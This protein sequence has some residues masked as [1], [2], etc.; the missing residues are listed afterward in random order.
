MNDLEDRL[1]EAI[2][3]AV[4]GAEPRPGVLS[5]VRRRH[6]RWLIRVTGAGAAAAIVVAGV[7]VPLALLSPGSRVATATGDGA[8]GPVT[9]YV[10]GEKGTVT[11]I[12]TATNTPLKTIS[13]RGVDSLG[14]VLTPDGK[15]AYVLNDVLPAIVPSTVT[16]VR[17]ATNTALTPIK[18][19]AGARHFAMAPDGKTLY[20]ANVYSGTVTPIR[21]AT[22]I[23]LRPIKVGRHPEGIAVTPDSKTVYVAN[24]LAGTVTP[25]QAATGKALKPIKV[26]GYPWAIAI[27]PNGKTAY[28]ATAYGVVP[29]ATATNTALPLIRAGR[30]ALD[31]AITPN[32]STA[33]ALT[34]NGVTLIRTRHRHHP[35][36]GLGKA[37]PHRHRDHAGQRDRLR[38]RPSR[39]GDPHQHCD[40]QGTGP[41][42]GGEGCT[43]HRD[44]P[45]RQ[46]RL[47][48]ALSW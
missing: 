4:A 34:A 41:D 8:G 26:G 1:R 19:G 47:R 24:Y 22:N 38:H 17:T 44:H 21:T 14:I 7:V 9:A 10:V 39:R 29:I 40:R 13:D 15:T 48:H 31:V 27:T 37:G 30:G 11:P 16:P 25:I 23:T 2:N 42:R 45:G 36:A 35:A 12:R 33:Y 32:G 6:R 3:A 20:V 46:D 28:V 5:A 43:G 18:V